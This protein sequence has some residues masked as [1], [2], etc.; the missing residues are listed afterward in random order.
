[1]ALAVAEVIA[2]RM[3]TLDTFNEIP[4][5][6][7]APSSV[8]RALGALDGQLLQ[9]LEGIR[10]IESASSGAGDEVLT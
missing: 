4:P 5:L 6:L 9:I 3:I 2:T 8:T 10:I 1:V 7:A